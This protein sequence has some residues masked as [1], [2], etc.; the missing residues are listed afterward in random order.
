MGSQDDVMNVVKWLFWNFL[1]CLQLFSR[2][3]NICGGKKIGKMNSAKFTELTTFLEKVTWSSSQ[4]H[5]KNFIY[6]KVFSM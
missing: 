5:Y 6:Q 4:N 1:E 3:V 2:N